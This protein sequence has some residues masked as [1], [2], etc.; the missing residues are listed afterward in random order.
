MTKYE[1]ISYYEALGDDSKLVCVDSFDSTDDI[2]SK[3]TEKANEVGNDKILIEVFHDEIGVQSYTALRQTSENNEILFDVWSNMAK[4]TEKGT[5]KTIAAVISDNMPKT[6]KSPYTKYIDSEDRDGVFT[7]KSFDDSNFSETMHLIELIAYSQSIS[8]TEKILGEFDMGE[9]EFHPINH[10]ALNMFDPILSKISSK[11]IRLYAETCLQTI[12]EYVFTASASD[13]SDKRSASDLTEGGLLRHLINTANMI[14]HLTELD[15]AK[16]KFSQHEIDMMIVAALLHDSFK[17]GWQ[18]DYEADGSEK[19]EHPRLAA[20]VMRCIRGIIPDN[21]IK[22]ITNSIE[23]HMGNNNIDPNN[24]NCTPLPTPDTEC[25][26]MIQLADFLA[27]RKDITFTHS[28]TIYALSTQQ[29]KSVKNFKKIS[30]AEKNILTNALDMQI[31]T[32]LAAELNIHRDESLIKSIWEHII[33][34]QRVT[35]RQLK[36]VE[37]ATRMMFD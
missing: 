12:P 11:S 2:I 29:I 18:K 7:I 14:I 28:D 30:D 26:Y 10:T 16:I 35:D 21:D 20:N 37:L 6:V 25:K 24:I 5:I 9:K 31:D 1:T 34:T 8:E 36:Y 17:Y 15:Y 4:I 27:T 3:I 13:D 22:F 23:S 33:E 32:S 19:F